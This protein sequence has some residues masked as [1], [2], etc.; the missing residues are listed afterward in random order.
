MRVTRFIIILILGV[1]GA[2]LGTPRAQDRRLPET[3]SQAGRRVALTIGNDAY[4][5]ARLKNAR[6]DATVVG[7]AL[8][9]LGFAVT[10][11][12][13]AGRTVLTEALTRFAAD[14]RADDIAFFYYAGH[15]AQVEGENYLIPVDYPTN[16]SEVAIRMT[17]IRASEVQQVLRR[18]RVSVIVLDACRV[19]P[20]AGARAGTGGLAPIEAKGSLVAYATGANQ[21]ASDNSS[22]ANG[23]FTGELVRLLLTPGLSIREVFY[24]VRRKVFDLSGGNQFPAVYDQLLSD[25]VLRPGSAPSSQPPAVQPTAIQPPASGANFELALWDAVKSTSDPA[26]LEDFL[27]QYPSTTFRAVAEARV[28]ELRDAEDRRRAEAAAAGSA[29]GGRAGRGGAAAGAG[30]GRGGDVSAGGGRSGVVPTSGGRAGDTPPPGLGGRGGGRGGVVSLGVSLEREKR[31]AEAE[32]AFVDAANRSDA[33]VTAHLELAAYFARRYKWQSSE[34]E[35]RKIVK[36]DPS[37]PSRHFSL[38]VALGLQSEARGDFEEALKL[39]GAAGYSPQTEAAWRCRF[40]E[41]LID[42]GDKGDARRQLFLVG[43]STISC[44]LQAELYTRLGD[45]SEAEA[46]ARAYAAALPPSSPYG[47]LRLSWVLHAIGKDAEADRELQAAI[48]DLAP[49]YETGVALYL[50]EH[51]FKLS[52]VHDLLQKASGRAQGAP[53]STLLEALGWSFLKSGNLAEA[54]RNLKAA[55]EMDLQDRGLVRASIE[56]RLAELYERRGQKALAAAALNKA[57]AAV[58]PHSKVW[59]DIKQKLGTLG[60]GE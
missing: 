19:N 32:A 16:A 29:G 15:G 31:Y 37:N 47:H 57:L 27:R 44:A 22:G 54:E 3:S 42:V 23:L 18:A 35:Y 38:A 5:A 9:E 12:Q 14:L 28:K 41:Y 34:A 48:A 20:F 17:G 36:I 43:T 33:D 60:P 10:T 4:P 56:Q 52:V 24:Q 53:T 25:L 7:G 49:N 51:D 30:G 26:L 40:A 55:E 1:V 13:D 21:V 45:K 50:L 39:G 46:V 8:R 6:N 2:A 58:V 11:V 59:N